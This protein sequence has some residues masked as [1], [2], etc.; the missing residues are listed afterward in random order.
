MDPVVLHSGEGD[1]DEG[2]EAAEMGETVEERGKLTPDEYV[3][4][5][6]YQDWTVRRLYRPTEEVEYLADQNQDGVLEDYRDEPTVLIPV[7]RFEKNGITVA[8]GNVR[9]VSYA[10]SHSLVTETREAN[11]LLSKTYGYPERAFL[12]TRKEFDYD[13]YGNK[14]L[15]RITGSKTRPMMM[16]V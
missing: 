2:C 3:Y 5:R 1:F 7:G 15:E 10:F 14:I 8:S 16:S 4:T 13:D 6:S 9:S 11:G 12:Q